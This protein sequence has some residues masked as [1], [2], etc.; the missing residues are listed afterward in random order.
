MAIDTVLFDMY[1]TLGIEVDY[2]NFTAVLVEHGFPENVAHE[3]RHRADMNAYDGVEHHEHSADRDKYM[4]WTRSK[5]VEAL[6][7]FSTEPSLAETLADKYDA[8]DREFR[9]RMRPYP[10]SRDVLKTLQ[11]RGFRIAVCSNWTWDILDVVASL[12]VSDRWAGVFSS[13]QLGARKPNP[14][15]FEKIMSMLQVTPDQCLFVGD[16]WTSDIIGAI[17]VGMKSVYV[18]RKQTGL[19]EQ[20]DDVFHATDLSGVLDAIDTWS[21]S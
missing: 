21:G 13:A 14:V 1:G 9:Q 17:G 5:A 18:D 8:W 20:R 2:D 10:E 15:F 3:I 16:T 4:Q 19:L 7:E 6:L 12:D 11:E